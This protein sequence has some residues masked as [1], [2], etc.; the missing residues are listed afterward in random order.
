M[1]V[2][3][4]T[5]RRLYCDEKKSSVDIGREIGAS[6]STVCK[7][8]KDAG[9]QARTRA[10][11]GR[12]GSAKN[13]G[14]KREFTTE[15]KAKLSAAGKRFGEANAKGTSLKPN[16]YVEYTRGE[17][18]GRAVHIVAMENHL[19]RKLL[20]N[21]IVHHKDENR[22][23]NELSNL[24]L[25]TRSEHAR[26]H[27]EEEKERG[28][29]RVKITQKQAEKIRTLYAAGDITTRLLGERFGISG[30]Q[31]SCIIRGEAWK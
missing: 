15:W 2:Q 23:N 30:K 29:G 19:G 6:A 10:E 18:K 26:H 7:W 25:M 11:G 17:N 8:L 20:P 27:R 9:I 12:M 21:E 5:L 4:E 31:V 28:T 14:K 13:R 24:E 1:K 16:G 22:S 3:P